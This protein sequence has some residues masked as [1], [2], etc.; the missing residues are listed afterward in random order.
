[1]LE[2][3]SAFRTLPLNF[4]RIKIIKM[5]VVKKFQI[6]NEIVSRKNTSG[7]YSYLCHVIG[8]SGIRLQWLFAHE[9][10]IEKV[11]RFE[12]DLKHELSLAREKR[13]V[14]RNNVKNRRGFIG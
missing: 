3:H 8:K 14:R 4:V 11:I 6:S 9:I 12:Q 13:L 1:M 7:V 2:H 5:P 10:P